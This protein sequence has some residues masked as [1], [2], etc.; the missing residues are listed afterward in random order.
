MTRPVQSLEDRHTA[1][2]R[3]APFDSRAGFLVAGLVAAGSLVFITMVMGIAF[4]LTANPDTPALSNDFRV[5]W[6]AGRLAVAGEPLAIHDLA[7]LGASHATGLDVIMPWLYPP[8]FLVMV[9]PLGLMPF[10]W[11]YLGW[12]VASLAMVAWAA[13]SFVAGIGPVWVLMALAPAYFPCV[14]MGQTSLFWLAALLA[15]LA[16][17][18]QGRYVVAGVFIGLLTLKPQLGVMIPLALLA[19]G[20]WRTILSACVTTVLLLALPT[21]Y[22]GLDYWPL[23]GKTLEDH[24]TNII[25]SIIALKLMLNPMYFLAFIGVDP[26]VA[27]NIQLGLM[28]LSAVAVFALWRSDRVG[29]DVKAAGLLC[30]IMLSAPYLWY[31]EGALMPAIAL[32]LLRGGVLS[33]RPLHMLLLVPLLIG[34]GAQALNVFTALFDQRWLGAAIIPPLVMVCFVLCLAQIV[35]P[36]ATAPA[37]A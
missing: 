10:A 28:A 30:A 16:A 5:F 35:A 13:R 26:E 6:G 22:Y 37:S 1:D 36:R 3:L 12:A 34:G 29:F 24:G 27:M 25:F 23:L 18:S 11:A 4:L 7:R 17:L 33:V 21:L 15:A 32:F 8:A 31:Y 14:M 19:I 2:A 9:T 20:A